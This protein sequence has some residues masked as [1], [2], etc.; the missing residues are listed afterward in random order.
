M[1]YDRLV[2]ELLAN[3]AESELEL[4]WFY[5]AN[6][7]NGDAIAV[8]SVAKVN[9]EKRGDKYLVVPRVRRVEE[10]LKNG[11]IE[12]F[13]NQGVSFKD[14]LSALGFETYLNYHNEARK[15]FVRNVKEGRLLSLG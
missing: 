11:S 4:F 7:F 6:V 15:E 13:F 10:F 3:G 1:S 9:G 2:E 14:G 5:C 12:D 8:R